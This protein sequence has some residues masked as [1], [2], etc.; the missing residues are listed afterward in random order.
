[1]AAVLPPQADPHW[2]NGGTFR[3]YSDDLPFGWAG[4][5]S[6]GQSD[7]VKDTGS[8]IVS[9]TFGPVTVVLPVTCS[10]F[11]MGVEDPEFRQRALA[12]FEAKEGWAIE[13]ELSQG[14]WQPLNP[15][16]AD[17]NADVLA[18]GAA[19]SAVEGLALLEKAIGDTAQAGVIHAD[20]ATATAWAQ[21]SLI[22]KDGNV[23]RTT[24][25]TPVAVG[26][27]YTGAQP[28]GEAAAGADQG[29]AFAS[30]QIV[31]R[32]DADE[33][34]PSTLSEALDRHTNEV[35]EYAERTYLVNWD[36]SLQAAVLIDRS[37]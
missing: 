34:I 4:C 24:L 3:G 22:A 33:I 30:G 28:D 19:V 26:G 23:L 17:S 1:V 2:M 13:R 35:T 11:S 8:G 25:G 6:G 10:A 20:P 9:P 5:L 12:A 37:V 14:V 31:V 15:F 16:L 27:G 18:A 32:R 29:W 36:V 7:A 21:W